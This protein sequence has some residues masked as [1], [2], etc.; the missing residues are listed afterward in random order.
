MY[1]S[2]DQHNS[3]EIA[4]DKVDPTVDEGKVVDETPSR[5]DPRS[6]DQARTPSRY[7]K[8]QCTVE[9]AEFRAMALLH[10]NELYE[11]AAEEL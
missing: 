8:R 5:P 3:V 9:R 2:L 11:F 4:M 1:G 7:S 10:L 6:Y